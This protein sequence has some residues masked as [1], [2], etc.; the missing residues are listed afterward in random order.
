MA[1]LLWALACQRVITDQESNSVSY[2][3]AVEQ[4]SV[5]KL[6]FQFPPFTVAT[7]WKREK[8]GEKINMRLGVFGPDDKTIVDFEPEPGE[9][10]TALR[11][12]MNLTLG[13]LP[14]TAA[15]Q[16][17]IEVQQKVK[18]KWRTEGELQIDVTQVTRPAES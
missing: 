14:I 11:H 7:L 5:P 13:G 15:G 10:E 12:R 17:R 18:G 6:P 3:D 9:S 16:H 8:R 2:I 1:K 4:L